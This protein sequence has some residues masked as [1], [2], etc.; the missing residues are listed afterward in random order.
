MADSMRERV[1]RIGRLRYS[2]RLSKRV[3]WL[4]LGF[5]ACVA[6]YRDLM[7]RGEYS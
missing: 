3:T 7:E 1:G 6:H 2:L 4:Y 5:S